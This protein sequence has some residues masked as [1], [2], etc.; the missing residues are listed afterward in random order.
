[1][2]GDDIGELIQVLG[3]GIVFVWFLSFIISQ[4][5]W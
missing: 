4:L 2:N 5:N 1:M 3:L